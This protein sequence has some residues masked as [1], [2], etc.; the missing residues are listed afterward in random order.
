MKNQAEKV[1]ILR[2]KFWVE[3]VENVLR[4]IMKNMKLGGKSVFEIK[5]Y[6]GENVQK[7][8]FSRNW[9]FGKLEYS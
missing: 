7:C 8:K 5:S 9:S 1:N 2:N 3:K 4:K 6:F